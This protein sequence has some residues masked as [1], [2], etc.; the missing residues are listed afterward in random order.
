MIVG[1]K[2]RWSSVCEKCKAEIT[3][4][5]SFTMLHGRRWHSH[6]AVQYLSGRRRI[7]T[8]A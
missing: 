4:G 8:K 6:C 1:V 3:V 7:Q 5:A 2:A